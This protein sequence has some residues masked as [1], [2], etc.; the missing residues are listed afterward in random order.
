MKRH[1]FK[2]VLAIVLA[3]STVFSFGSPAEATG[4]RQTV[5]SRPSADRAPTRT[6]L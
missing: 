5:L 3:L 1:L 4:E 2:S 6:A